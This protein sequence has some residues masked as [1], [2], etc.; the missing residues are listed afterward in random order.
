M[1]DLLT[2]HN[3][4][5]TDRDDIKQLAGA[6]TLTVLAR[7]DGYRKGS[8]VRFLYGAGLIDRDPTIV[9]LSG[10]NLIGTILIRD[11]LSNANFSGAFLTDSYLMATSLI[12]AK[13]TFTVLYG[14]DLSLVDL[15]SADLSGA[16]LSGADLSDAVVTEE[17]L[18]TCISLENATMP[19]GQKYKA[20][21]K[22]RPNFK[23]E[24]EPTPS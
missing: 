7:L 10:A 8:V 19:D 17:Q 2:D 16:N 6:Q 5:S 1:G 21:R 4:I 11:D 13:L 3:L 23:L 15:T 9:G 20:W 12:R 14:A 24:E 18:A 22:T